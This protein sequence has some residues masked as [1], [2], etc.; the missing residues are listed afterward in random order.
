MAI[1]VK[2]I[3]LAAFVC[4]ISGFPAM[5]GQ[6]EQEKLVDLLSVDEIPLQNAL[7]TAGDGHIRNKRTL[8]E[9]LNLFKYPVGSFGQGGEGAIRVFS[10]FPRHFFPQVLEGSGNLMATATLLTIL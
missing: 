2:A 3:M 5:S 8:F 9:I 6:E 10:D 7:S 4:T 1:F